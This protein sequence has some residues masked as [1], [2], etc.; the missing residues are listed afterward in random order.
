[1]IRRLIAFVAGDMTTA[2]DLGG[3]PPPETPPLIVRARTDQA[4]AKFLL[5]VAQAARDRSDAAV[6]GMQSKATSFLT[7]VIGLFPL[8]LAAVALAVPSDS[9]SGVRWIAFGIVAAAVVALT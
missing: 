3:Y 5:D 9:A 1:M 7:L 2:E 4:L 6:A 8:F